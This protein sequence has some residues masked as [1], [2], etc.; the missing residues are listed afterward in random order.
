[1]TTTGTTERRMTR[2]EQLAIGAWCCATGS[3]ISGA[4]VTSRD[5][6]PQVLGLG[7]RS[8]APEIPRSRKTTGNPP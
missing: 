3:Q 6:N 7:T 2:I 8:L 1:M 4:G 5:A